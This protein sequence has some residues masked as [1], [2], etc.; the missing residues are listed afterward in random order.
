MTDFF[1]PK[2]GR[3]NPYF[4]SLLKEGTSTSPIGAHSQGMSR[5]AFALL[6]GLERNE[7]E[8]RERIALAGSPLQKYP[9]A[10]PGQDGSPI[11][12]D[13]KLR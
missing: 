9:L 13:N 7:M 12:P 1:L 5:L 8:Q 6:A 4:E 3:R 10:S 11:F 2:Y